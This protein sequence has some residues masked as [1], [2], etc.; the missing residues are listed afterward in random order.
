MTRKVQVLSLSLAGACGL[1]ASRA[2]AQFLAGNVWPNPDLSVAAAPGVDQVYSYYNTPYYT[3]NTVGDTNPRPDGWHRG[4][5]DFATTSTPELTF[6]NTPGNSAG[7][8]TAPAGLNGYAL[9]VSD[10]DV[11]NYG[12]W[13]SDWNALPASVLANPGETFELQFFYETQGVEPRGDT[14]RVSAYFGDSTGDDTLTAPNQIGNSTDYLIAGGSPDVT[15]WTQVDELLTAPVNAESM[16]ITIDS[17][18]TS[19]ATGT[20]WVGDISVAEVPE[21]TCIAGMTAGSMLL[22]ARRRRRA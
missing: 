4:G 2:S 10:S 16:R 1:I 9:E 22:L 5:G 19:G 12:E 3:P 14:F 13:F 20:I 8:G 17:G 6:Y 11:N 18:G 21:P 15:S 7:E